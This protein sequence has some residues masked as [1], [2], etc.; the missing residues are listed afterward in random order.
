LGDFDTELGIYYC[1]AC[2]KTAERIEASIQRGNTRIVKYSKFLKERA[3]PNQLLQIPQVIVT[4]EFAKQTATSL[5]NLRGAIQINEREA[6]HKERVSEAKLQLAKDKEAKLVQAKQAAEVAMEVHKAQATVALVRTKEAEARAAMAEA[7]AVSN[8]VRLPDGQAFRQL[9]FAGFIDQ[10]IPALPFVFGQPVVA[11]QTPPTVKPKL[12]P[13]KL[14]MQNGGNEEQW[15]KKK[16]EEKKLREFK[17]EALTCY[18]RSKEQ[19][20]Y[21]KNGCLKLMDQLR[22]KAKDGLVA[23]KRGDALEAFCLVNGATPEEVEQVNAAVELED[24][25][26]V[27]EQSDEEKEE[28]EEEDED[29][30]EEEKKNESDEDEES[31]DDD[32]N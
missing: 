15:K 22:T 3:K 4:Q 18:Q 12:S 16:A 20:E 2:P 24:Q 6:D 11:I 27:E 30:E 9:E 23:Q 17:K 13:K 21:Y 25:L 29:E 14:F 7:N 8:F 1:K 26:E 32:D 28:D 10:R 5:E 19:K 31:D